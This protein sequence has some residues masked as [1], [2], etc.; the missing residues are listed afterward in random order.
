MPDKS[1]IHH[2]D[3]ELTP[4][5]RENLEIDLVNFNLA[6]SAAKDEYLFA[7][8]YKIVDTI[9]SIHNHNLKLQESLLLLDR[10]HDQLRGK[11]SKLEEQLKLLKN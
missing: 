7:L 9:N 8:F 2:T 3:I 1:P 4:I 5:S 11:I 10:E 6:S